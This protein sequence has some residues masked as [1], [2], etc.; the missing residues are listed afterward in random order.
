MYWEPRSMLLLLGPDK[1]TCV[2]PVYSTDVQ[3]APSF[4]SFDRYPGLDFHNVF[5]Y[6][7]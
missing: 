7:W 5:D 6:Q 3:S 1:L 2:C 4:E